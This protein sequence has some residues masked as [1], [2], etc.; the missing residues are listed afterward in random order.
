ME[1]ESGANS[2]I[3]QRRSPHH[4]ES[5]SKFYAYISGPGCSKHR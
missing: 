3:K 5:A 2:I 1:K 4:T